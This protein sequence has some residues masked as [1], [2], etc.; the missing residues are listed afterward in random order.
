[1][2]PASPTRNLDMTK[3]LLVL[4]VTCVYSLSLTRLEINGHA[5]TSCMANLANAGF[6]PK[7]NTNGEI[8]IKFVPSVKT[9]WMCRNVSFWSYN[10]YNLQQTKH[11]FFFHT[12]EDCKAFTTNTVSTS[13]ADVEIRASCEKDMTMTMFVFPNNVAGNVNN[14]TYGVSVSHGGVAFPHIAAFQQDVIG[15]GTSAV[16]RSLYPKACGSNVILHF[17]D[18]DTRSMCYQSLNISNAHHPCEFSGRGSKADEAVSFGVTVSAEYN[19]ALPLS[20]ACQHASAIE[21][22]GIKSLMDLQTNSVA[23]CQKLFHSSPHIYVSG[24]QGEYAMISPCF[25]GVKNPTGPST[26]NIHLSVNGNYYLHI[27]AGPEETVN[28]AYIKVEKMQSA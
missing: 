24:F 7:E 6:K 17:R 1:V 14:P 4:A 27:K 3:F 12:S 21:L 22:E 9:P 5:K 8:S 2:I 16:P 20:K 11:T 10:S 25:A 23:D 26:N 28:I 19:I 18:S 13:N 15:M